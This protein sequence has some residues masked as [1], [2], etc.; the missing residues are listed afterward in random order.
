MTQ[1]SSD[2]APDLLASVLEAY[3]EAPDGA[4]SNE[5]LYAAVADAGALPAEEM[6]RVA[7]VG[8]AS[9]AWA[10]LSAAPP[11]AFGS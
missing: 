7:P 1:T 5:Q 10:W 3:L 6:T 2:T 8:E 9:K 4:L 11:A